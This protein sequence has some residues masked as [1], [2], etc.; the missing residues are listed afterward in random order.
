M[1]VKVSLN[2]ERN[3]LLD[4]E[5]N[6][7]GSVNIKGVTWKLTSVSNISDKAVTFCSAFTAYIQILVS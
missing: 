4:H 3:I 6:I 7:Y 5:S 2:E 1:Q